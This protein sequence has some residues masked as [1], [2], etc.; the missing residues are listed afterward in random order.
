MRISKVHMYI[1]I[2]PCLFVLFQNCAGENFRPIESS[3]T[4]SFCKAQP[5]LDNPFQKSQVQLPETWFM[6]MRKASSE[7]TEL[8]LLIDVPC[9]LED[10]NLSFLGQSLKLKDS[11]KILTKAAYS[12]YIQNMPQLAELED[13][14]QQQNCILG[15]TENI[16]VKKSQV[17][18]AANVNDPQA[19]Q[20]RHLGFIGYDSSRPLANAITSKVTVAVIDSGIEYTHTDLTNRMWVDGSGNHGYNF[21]ADNFSPLDDDGHG[22]HVSGIIAAEEN[23]SFAVTGLTGSFVELMAIKVL[24]ATGSGT[25]QN[26]HDGIQYAISNGADIINLSVESIGTN[27]L[28]E[29]AIRDAIN[30]GIVVTM[31]TGNQGQQMT[32]TN[33]FAPGSLG[34]QLGGAISVASV[35]SQT[36]ALSKFS[37]YSSTYA[38]IA[39]PGAESSNGANV[40]IMS[41]A[42]RNGFER[43]RGTSQSTPMVTASAALLIGY[44]KTKNIQYTPQAIE[45]FIKRS[46]VVKSSILSSFVNGGDILHLGMLSSNL[47][48]YFEE[49]P[50]PEPGNQFDGTKGSSATC[51]IN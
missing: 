38:E 27:A 7:P 33:V 47:I 14:V 17:F 37:N 30:A 41:T 4:F 26:V 24:D 44:L 16:S 50:N 5:Q 23:N 48:T 21:V 42:I 28:M 49:N 9:A 32:A 46:G 6:G 35:D 31:A 18:V 15:V 36:G 51:H 22:T 10:N 3:E 29:S 20:Q 25:S 11:Q 39:A 34:P 45:T 8:T 40:G 12:I 43:I 19:S 2:F 1:F 13:E